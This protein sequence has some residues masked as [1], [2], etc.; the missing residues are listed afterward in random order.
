[1][2][3]VGGAIS[4]NKTFTVTADYQKQNWNDVSNK[5]FGSLGYSLV[6]SDR[7]SGGVEYSKNLKYRSLLLEKWYLQAGAFYTNSYLRVSGEQITQ[8]GFTVG[9]GISPLKI[10]F[11]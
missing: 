7:I 5:A 1:M 9:A 3:T 6:N 11:S 4:Y 2:Y 10:P 8:G